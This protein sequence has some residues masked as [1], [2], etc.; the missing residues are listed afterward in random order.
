M[1]GSE[2]IQIHKLRQL[3]LRNASAQMAVYNDG[4]IV[5]AVC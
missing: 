2:I 3:F 4:A 1:S 5:L